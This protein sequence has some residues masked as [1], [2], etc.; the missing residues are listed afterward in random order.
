VTFLETA[1]IV[2]IILGTFVLI[3]LFGTHAI[4]AILFIGKEIRK[5][6]IGE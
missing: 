5:H 2:V 4:R 3:A 1:R 6:G